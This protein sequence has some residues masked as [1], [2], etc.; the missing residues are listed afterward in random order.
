MREIYEYRLS[1]LVPGLRGMA[2]IVHSLKAFEN[3]QN[4]KFVD[5]KKLLLILIKEMVIFY[6]KKRSNCK[7]T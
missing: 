2:L 6:G 7:G 5:L 3:Q 1:R 4:I